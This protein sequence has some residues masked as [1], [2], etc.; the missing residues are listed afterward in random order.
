MI[1]KESVDLTISLKDSKYYL[2]REL[3]WLEF[4]YRVLNEALDTRTPLLERL[5]FTA[6]FSSN[7]DE[8]F[9]VRIA[10]LK[11]Q[12][13]A[14]VTKLTFDGCTPLEQ[15]VAISERLH[16]LIKEQDYLFEYTLRNLL[17]VQGIH[18]VN[19]I[20]LDQKQRTYLHQYFDENI[21]PVLTP[22]VVDKSHP[23]PYISN[24]SLNLGVVICNPETKEEHF[25]R[26]KVPSVLPRFVALPQRLYSQTNNKSI[27]WQG[28]PLEQVIAHNIE[29]L[30]SGMIVQECYPFRVTRNADLSVEEDEADDLLLAIEQELR[31]RNIGR[32]AV[33]LEV[34]A[35]TPTLIRQQLVED[36]ELEEIDVYD[37]Q[38]LLGLKDLLYFLSLPYPKLKYESWSSIVPKDLN[39]IKKI[40]SSNN[41]KI[42][43]NEKDIFSLIRQSDI[44]VH[45]PYQSFS[46]SVEQFIAQAAYDPSVLTIKMT[47]YRTSGDSPIIEALIA[48]AA[49]DKQVVTLIELK[50]RFDEENNI[51]WARQLE[52]SG[53]HVVYGLAGLKTHTKIVLIVRKEGEKIRRYVHIG[54]GNYNS[55]TA[56]LYTDVGLFSCREELGADLTDLFNFL[57]GYSCQKLYRK[58]LVA[59]V[60]MRD[61]ILSMINREI[62]HCRKG[63]KGHIVAKMNSL[64]D[65]KIIEALYLASQV[66]VKIDLIIR[67][68]CC[69]RPGIKGISNNIRVISV[70]GRFLEH[71][72]IFYLYNGGKKEVYIGSA[73]W[74]TRNFVRRVEAI[75]LVNDPN[76]SYKLEEILRITLEDNSQA[77]QLSSNGNYIRRF[78][79]SNQYEKNS[80]KIFMEMALKSIL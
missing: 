67:G 34:H 52:Q 70:I 7:L 4:N 60:N 13:Q 51:I 40:T 2:N 71:S 76:I 62:T 19:Y 12:I 22:L 3:S 15:L 74:M 75:T 32:S 66:G 46:A 54:T 47:L 14:G 78:P 26:V 69:L 36:L 56:N 58:L 61:R 25:A 55:K 49:N 31:K 44:L 35:S 68:I 9:M 80:Q 42:E 27:V 1:Q 65:P 28:I 23:F 29:A 10:G 79:M 33:R 39:K 73:D 64:V 59:P 57:T 20:D 21:F 6:I 37:I 30:F 17:A 50:A 8:F 77:W 5:K 38:G 24:L 72:R 16:F 41:Q 43:S 11:Q 53:V 63:G 48:A 45:H 18:L